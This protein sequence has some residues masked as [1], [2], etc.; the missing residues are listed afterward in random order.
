M[1]YQNIRKVNSHIV[2]VLTIINNQHIL[3][4]LEKKLFHLNIGMETLGRKMIDLRD[5]LYSNDLEH[6]KDP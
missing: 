5:T 6:T 1:L 3:M 2:E 4:D